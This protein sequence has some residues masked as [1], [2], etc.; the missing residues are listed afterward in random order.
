MILKIVNDAM[1]EASEEMYMLITILAECRVRMLALRGKPPG[2][3]Q[4]G[5]EV[6]HIR[7]RLSADRGG[8]RH[9]QQKKR[10]FWDRQATL[11]IAKEGS[12][13]NM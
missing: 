13:E 6:T 11:K 3:H 5:L 4:L 7:R 2:P 1:S 9:G 12:I 10:R 8:R